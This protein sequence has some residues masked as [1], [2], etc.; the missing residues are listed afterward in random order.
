MSL[1][2]SLSQTLNI[3]VQFIVYIFMITII[4]RVISKITVATIPEE[5]R[6]LMRG[7]I[8]SKNWRIAS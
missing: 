3:L 8:S 5:A 7:A 4:L 1:S 2:E 6:K